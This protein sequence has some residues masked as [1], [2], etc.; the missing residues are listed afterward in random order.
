MHTRSSPLDAASTRSIWHF[1]FNKYK[2]YLPGFTFLV[3]AHPGSPGHSSG[4]HETVVVVVVVSISKL[5]HQTQRQ[6]YF[7]DRHT[8]ENTINIK[9]QKQVSANASGSRVA[10]TSDRPC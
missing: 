5:L 9:L 7:I 1:Y 8:N 3:P 10:I 2:F 6:N 4:G